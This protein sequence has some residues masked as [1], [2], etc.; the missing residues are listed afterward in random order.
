MAQARI[1]IRSILQR[2]MGLHQQGKVAEAE[3]LYHEVLAVEPNEPNAWHL[4]GVVA[5]NRNDLAV[6]EEN[7]RKAIGLNG[8][9]SAYYSNLA[10]V[11]RQKGDLGDAV[12]HY[13]KALKLSP[14][15]ETVKKEL[16]QTLHRYA[17]E[18]A[19]ER[20]WDQAITAYRRVL[21]LEPDN[22]ATLNNLASVVQ[23]LNDRPE[24]YRLYGH[25]LKVMPDNL[26]LRYNRSIC[27]LTDRKFAE[28][29]ADFTASEP[30][31]RNMQDGR[32]DLPWMGL[33]L[34]NGSD[35]LR[36]KKILIWGD[37]GIGDEIVY[38]SCIPDLI[39]RG[40]VVTIECTDRLVPLL[41]RSFP[42]ATALPRRPQP[43]PGADFD[44]HAPGLWLARCLRPT[45]A[46]FPQRKF[47]LKADAEKTAHLR[48]RYE[49]F[50]KKRIIGVS[51]FTQSPAYGL[52][53]SIPLPDILKALLLDDILVVD[54]QYGNTEAA[55]QQA[56]QM[57]PNLTMIHDAEV[58]QF[59]DMDIYAA[60]VAACD[61]VVTICNTTSHVAGALGIPA[62]VLMSDIGLTW[63]WFADGEDC[64]WYP[65]LKLLRPN[66]PDRL[67]AAAEM[68][69]SNQAC[70]R[71]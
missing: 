25:A 27:Y 53:R 71:F 40:A 10:G 55:W 23:H 52:Q 46:S 19:R 2:A 49:A 8:N 21:E 18:L 28:G 33:L 22:V 51:W 30:Y 63:Y 13:E 64:P 31:W 6:A 47:F 12:R 58:D 44:F 11:L 14:A 35:D 7:I 29:W 36:G 54:L 34:W 16:S 1:D 32:P 20:I 62:S 70:D 56:R 67:R 42:E 41:Q 17:L 57:F 5:W 39:E 43:L 9:A 48:Q 24:A 37:Q 45:M 69:K 59:K 15:D 65:S 50:G 60:Q 3:T 61:A 4:L 38:D 66:V 26:Q 68:I